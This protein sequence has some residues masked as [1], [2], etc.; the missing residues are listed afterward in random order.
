MN[1]D[2]RPAA[3]ARR[4][5]EV[6]RI[7]AV[8][9]GKGGVGKSLVAATL[10]ATLADA[11]RRVGLLDLDFAGSSAHVVLGAAR[12]LPHEDRGIVP[13]V[14][15]GV[16]FMSLVHYIGEAAAPLRGDADANAI[17]ELLAITRWGPLDLLLV[18]MPPGMGDATL[19]TIRLLPR[20]EFLVVATA[21]RMALPVVRRVLGFLQELRVPIVGAA[22][23]MAHGAGSVVAA[24]LAGVPFLG[25][26]PYDPTIE[27]VV[28][29]VPALLA[30]P[31]GQAVREMMR[32][33]G[34]G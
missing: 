20:A 28:G 9:S 29:D 13:P 17:A 22:E 16:R 33:A 21:S 23:N 32:R 24:A 18:D 14:V 10:A 27:D 12:G 30:T 7:V 8:S 4:L 19:E 6:G 31:F 34:L 11:G 2:P 3:I 15:A 25:A 5:G 1:G 26:L